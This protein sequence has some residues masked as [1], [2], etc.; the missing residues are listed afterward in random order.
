M[1]IYFGFAFSASMLPAGNVDM[2]K[3]DL[4]ID[5]VKAL[6]PEMEMCLNPSHVATVNAARDKYGLDFEIPERPARVSLAAGDS[7]VVMQVSGLPRLTDRREYTDE[8]IVGAQF[9]FLKIAVK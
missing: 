3:K 7:V 1:T 4:T 2:T 6:I 9:R 5:Q 8:E